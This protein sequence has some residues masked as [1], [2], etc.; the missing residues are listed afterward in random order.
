MLE[1]KTQDLMVN[2]QA[3][4][5]LIVTNALN[6]LGAIVILLI[7]LWLSGRA[8]LLVVRMLSRTPHFDATLKR[9]SSAASRA[10]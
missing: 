9:A 7:G 1:E 5:P 8:D 3:V 10:T 4:L 6:A 2:M